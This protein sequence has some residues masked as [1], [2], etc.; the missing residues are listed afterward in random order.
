MLLIDW[1]FIFI[2]NETTAFKA[3][4]IQEVNWIFETIVIHLLFL[5]VLQKLP[6]TAK[7]V[8]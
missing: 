2:L 8:A 4:G 7:K 5:P 3:K 1:P 6:E